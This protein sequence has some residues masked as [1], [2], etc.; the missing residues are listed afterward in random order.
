MPSPGLIYETAA[1]FRRDLL[2]RERKAASEMVRAYGQ[3]W[4]RIRMQLDDLTN[5]ITEARANGEDVSLS[6]LFQRN[7]L[8]ALQGQV[9]NE[10]REFARFAE[11]RIVAEQAEAVRAAQNHAVQLTLAGFGET[12]GVAVSLTRLSTAALTDLVGFQQNGSPLRNLLDELGPVASADVRRALIT[13]VATGQ[14]PRT[15]ARQV[16]NA[17][18]GSLARALRISRTEVMRS[19]REATHRNYEANAD[20]VVGWIWLAAKQART[21][22]MCLAM[23]GSVHDL[24]ERLDDHPNGRCTSIPALRGIARPKT[25]TGAEWFAAQNEETQRKVLGDAGYE[26]YRAGAVTLQDFVGRR[27]TK[28]WGTTRY[29]KSLKAALGP[30]EAVKWQGTAIAAL[31]QKQNAFKLNFDLDEAQPLGD[32]KDL[33]DLYPEEMPGREHLRPLPVVVNKWALDHIRNDHP[34]RVEWLSQNGHVARLVVESPDFVYSNLE[35][36][37]RMDHWAQMLVRKIEGEDDYLVM[38]LSLARLQ[39]EESDLHQAITMYLAREKTF[40]KIDNSGNKVLRPKWVP[41]TK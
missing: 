5:Q 4:Q 14:N 21:C 25:T 3:S 31:A 7:R 12:S 8:Q 6:W 13:G 41:V 27:R 28:A 23:D 17:V 9:E 32:L 20:I 18:G 24:D 40:F 1:R 2:Q 10:L 15:I 16:R 33:R 22:P 11:Q 30:E 19:Y 37:D 29:A 26:A 38:V 36:K 34:E 39:G 35:Y